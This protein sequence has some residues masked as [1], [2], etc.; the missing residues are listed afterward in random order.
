MLVRFSLV[1]PFYFPFFPTRT[2]SGV[3]DLQVLAPPVR[4]SSSTSRRGSRIYK[5]I[6]DFSPSHHHIGILAYYCTRDNLRPVHGHVRIDSFLL[7]MV[8]SGLATSVIDH[9]IV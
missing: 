2:A 7:Q 9:G 4:R 6:L 8:L 5:H 1:V 3:G